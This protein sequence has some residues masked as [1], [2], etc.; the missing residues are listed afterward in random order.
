MTDQIRPARPEDVESLHAMIEELAEYEREPD[1]VE[2]D[3]ADLR[4]A[5][6]DGADTP[7][8]APVLFGHV[9]E[10]DGEIAGMALWFLNYSTWRG[11][12]GIYLEDL[13]VRPQYRGRGLGRRLL[14]SLAEICVD[15]GY[16]RLDWMVLNWNGPALDFYRG[17]EAF[18]MDDWTVYRLTDDALTSLAAESGQDDPTGV[19]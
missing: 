4:R 8:G 1:A 5:L 18:P 11:Q 3:A 12:H 17:L 16:P 10:V 7:S 9:A 6:F 14:A 13:F 19:R 15:R 2:G